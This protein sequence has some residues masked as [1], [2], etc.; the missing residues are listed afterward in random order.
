MR[1]PNDRSQ[2]TSRVF[3]GCCMI[4]T[5]TLSLKKLT[6]IG[7]RQL[8][9]PKPSPA[10]APSAPPPKCPSLCCRPVLRHIAVRSTHPAN[11]RASQEQPRWTAHAQ[12]APTRPWPSPTPAMTPAAS[13]GRSPAALEAWKRGLDPCTESVL[14]SQGAGAAAASSDDCASQHSFRLPS[15]LPAL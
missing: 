1:E 6:L 11:L 12:G 8:E 10:A 2:L 13:F 4:R 5:N 14:A 15:L 9:G 3:H 7:C